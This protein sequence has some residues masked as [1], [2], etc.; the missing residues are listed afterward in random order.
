MNGNPNRPRILI[1][2]D[3]DEMLKFLS[4]LLKG[5][6]CDATAARSGL[7]ALSRLAED[8]D[9]NCVLTDLTMPYMDG[10]EFARY[11]KALRPCLTIIA[12]TG[13]DPNS[14]IPRLDGMGISHALFKPVKVEYIKAVI[15][16]FTQKEQETCIGQ[17]AMAH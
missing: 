11:A 5:L 15:A 4:H 12:L 2:D 6:G 13:L 8:G 14:V 3:D 16:C 10:W 17:S 7:E 1:V 9:Y